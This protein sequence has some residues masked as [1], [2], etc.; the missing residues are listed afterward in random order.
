M[1]DSSLLLVI[2]GF[3]ALATVRSCFLTWIDYRRKLAEHEA[4]LARW[5]QDARLMEIVARQFRGD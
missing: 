1:T 2:V 5:E 4:Q 3:A